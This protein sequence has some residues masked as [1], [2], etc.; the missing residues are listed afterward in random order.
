MPTDVCLGRAKS[1]TERHLPI[2]RMMVNLN[3]GKRRSRIA[4]VEHFVPIDNPQSTMLQTLQARE[5]G[6]PP[7]SGT[8]DLFALRG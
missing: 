5:Y 3:G 4:E 7:E 8:G 6:S 1:T 2:E